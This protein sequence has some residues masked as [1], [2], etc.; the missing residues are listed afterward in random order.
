[1]PEGWDEILNFD[2]PDLEPT[3]RHA[4]PTPPGERV[5]ISVSTEG[6]ITDST[7]KVWREVR[8]LLRALG[9]SRRD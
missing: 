1:M 9:R 8:D 3:G 5:T 4:A 6:E 7:S 2:E